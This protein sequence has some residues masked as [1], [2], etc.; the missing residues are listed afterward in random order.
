MAWTNWVNAGGFLEYW[1]LNRGY[2]GQVCT[3]LDQVNTRAKTGDFLVWMETDTFSYYHTQFVQRKVNG[4]VYCTQHS[5]HYYNEKLSGRI[6][7]PKK[8]FENKNVYIVKFS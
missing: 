2:L 7:D 1:S 4:Y 6:N 5:P 8:Y 3:T